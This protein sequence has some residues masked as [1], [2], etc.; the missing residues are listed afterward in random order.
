[1]QVLKLVH[2]CLPPIV[3]W[4][5]QLLLSMGISTG[6]S[7]WAVAFELAHASFEFAGVFVDLISP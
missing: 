1:M 2:V 6:D 3:I 5:S 4:G 7:I